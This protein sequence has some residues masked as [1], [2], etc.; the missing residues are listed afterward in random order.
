M[1]GEIPPSRV[2]IMEDGERQVIE[3]DINQKIILA[4]KLGA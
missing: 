1:R 3:S 4:I 2:F